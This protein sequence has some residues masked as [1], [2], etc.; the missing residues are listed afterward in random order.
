MTTG[1]FICLRPFEKA[2]SATLDLEE[3]KNL[4]HGHPFYACLITLFLLSLAGVPP[5]GGFIAKLFLFQG[6]LDRGLWWMLF[7][8][9]LGSSIALF[10][11]LKPIALMYMEPGEEKRSFRFP[12]FLIPV[13]GFLAGFILLSGL[14]PFLFDFI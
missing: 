13:S 4:S 5:T 3:L 9:I 6:L 14:A 12:R 8:M 1:I 7:W 10:Y 2:D 11:Y